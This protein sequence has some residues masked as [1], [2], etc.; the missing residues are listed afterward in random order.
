MVREKRIEEIK[1]Y[2]ADNGSVS[3]DELCER[4][5]ISKNTVRRDV[6]GLVK[7]GALK[8]VYGGVSSVSTSLQESSYDARMA[9]ESD[10][11]A[12]IARRA[13]EFIE[14]GDSVFVDSGSTTG[15]IVDYL[16]DKKNVTV[17]TNNLDFIMKA[18]SL[19]NL[20]VIVFSGILDRDIMAFTGIDDQTAR[21]L[22]NFNFKKAFLSATGVTV[23]FGAM[24]S[25]LSETAYKSTAVEW[26]KERYLLV[27]K[28]K[29][30]S[31]TIKSFCRLEDI[32]C[33]ITDAAPPE[34]ISRAMRENGSRIIEVKRQQVE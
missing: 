29:F 31:V 17:V 18:I 9:L 2:V 11:K 10:A 26:A 33:L 30:G 15:R 32:D 12:Q 7:A 34:D 23:E 28:T 27:D 16:H 21:M 4:F 5:G 6:D 13:A 8:K 22:K 3:L 1:K 24:N 25:I 19:N 14:D 20:K